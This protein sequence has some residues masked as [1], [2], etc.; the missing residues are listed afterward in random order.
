M[1]P[2]HQITETDEVARALDR[3]ARRWPGLS[4]SKLLV[5]LVSVGSS[6][7]K[8]ETDTA[9]QDH[10]AAVLSSAGRYPEAF[11]ADYLDDLRADWPE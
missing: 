8:D 2:R 9:E 11:G 6:A 3:A 1:R 4:R 7:L 10:R 5:R